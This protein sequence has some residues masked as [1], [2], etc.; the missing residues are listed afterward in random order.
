MGVLNRK[1]VRDFRGSL[2]ILSTVVAIIAV[3]TGSFIG[4]GGVIKTVPLLMLLPLLA[5]VRSAREAA[6][7]IAP[8]SMTSMQATRVSGP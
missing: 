4:L 1:L 5:S 8:S 7:L 3:G 6:K 2:G